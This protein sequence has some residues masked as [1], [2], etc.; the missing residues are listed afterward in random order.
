ML[1]DDNKRFLIC[2]FCQFIQHG[3][4]GFVIWLSRDWLQ[5]INTRYRGLGR[6]LH[7]QGG[8]Y[9]HVYLISLFPIPLPLYSYFILPLALCYYVFLPQFVF[10]L[11]R[12]F[13]LP[14]SH[15]ALADLMTFFLHFYSAWF[16]PTTLF[17]FPCPTYT[18][19]TF[20][21]RTIT[22]FTTQF[23]PFPSQAHPTLHLFPHPPLPH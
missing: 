20:P 22:V 17:P 12:E 16:P 7:V 4:H 1:E 13:L 19:S 6:E 15:T 11:P 9:T 23:N 21:T 2:L 8:W 10:T 5:T 14:S 3:F 18:P